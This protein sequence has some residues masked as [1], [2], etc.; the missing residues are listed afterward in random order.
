MRVSCV[1]RSEHR[2]R[3]RE[4]A[5]GGLQP[6]KRK[7]YGFNYSLL[8]LCALAVTGCG[9]TRPSKYYELTIPDNAA[10][11]PAAN[12]Y[13]VSILVGPLNASHLYREDHIVYG[14]SGENMGTYE[15]QRWAEP[16]TEM[17]Q[18]VIYRSLR[19]SARYRSVESLRSST[20]GDYLLHGH[21][22][23]FKEITGSPMAGRLS[24]ELELRD[25]K[26]GATVWTHLYNH[27]EAASGKDVPAVV[28]ALNRNVH[29]AASEF[30]ANLDQYF[31]TH[32]PTAP[33]Q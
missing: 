5:C 3:H 30:A 22:Y 31:S 28:A 25:T 14:S 24:I 27:D 17:I 6:L 18:D 9:A 15:Y 33:A 26:T 13:P 29:R 8:L 7:L 1:W 16:P 2:L 11:P 4:H 20:R 23:D 12:A 32:P 10:D 21:L 19:S